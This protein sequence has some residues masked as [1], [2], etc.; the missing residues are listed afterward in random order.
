MPLY[1]SNADAMLDETAGAFTGA[2][3]LRKSTSICEGCQR[4]KNLTA[5]WF[6][7][8]AMP[9]GIDPTGYVKGWAAQL[10]L[11]EGSTLQV[12]RID[13]NLK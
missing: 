10:A 9:G 5:G 11:D 6:D 8:W 7:P 1:A 4:A 12:N 13:L 3:I 2:G